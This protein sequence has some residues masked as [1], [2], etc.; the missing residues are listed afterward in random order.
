M[1]DQINSPLQFGQAGRVTVAGGE[2]ELVSGVPDSH[3]SDDFYVENFRVINPNWYV[4]TG[5]A[6]SIP[7]RG[8]RDLVEDSVTWYG[9]LLSLAFQY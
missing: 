3:L 1:A 8:L 9:A 4:T 6:V 7:G 5:F 2:P